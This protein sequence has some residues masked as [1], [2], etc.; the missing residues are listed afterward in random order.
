MKI[1]VTDQTRIDVVQI[2]PVKHLVTYRAEPGKEGRACGVAEY[3]AILR[4]EGKIVF[5]SFLYEKDLKEALDDDFDDLRSAL[6]EDDYFEPFTGDVTADDV[7][8]FAENLQYDSN[9]DGLWSALRMIRDTATPYSKDLED[10][11]KVLA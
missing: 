9:L 10:W 8:E 3:K 5:V 4:I 11:F 2:M 1:D 6:R 7:W